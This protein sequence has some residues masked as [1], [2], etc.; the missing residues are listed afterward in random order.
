MESEETTAFSIDN[1]QEEDDDDEE[2]EA[3]KGKSKK[4]KASGK[5]GSPPKKKAKQGEVEA[6]PDTHEQ[7]KLVSGGTLKD[8]QKAGVDWLIA[9]HMNAS[10]SPRR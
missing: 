10:V 3:P 7:S 6:V 1:Q 4:R 8:F 5:K 9:R 2:A